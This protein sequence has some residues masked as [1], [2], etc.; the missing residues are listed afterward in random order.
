MQSYFPKSASTFSTLE[1][2]VD[3]TMTKT[4]LKMWLVSTDFQSIIIPK[5]THRIVFLIVLCIYESKVLLENGLIKVN[6][7][8]F[9]EGNSSMYMFVSLL[10]TGLIQV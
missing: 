2:L 5:G 10:N 8:A 9:R 7:C 4:D 3:Q 6:K 1:S